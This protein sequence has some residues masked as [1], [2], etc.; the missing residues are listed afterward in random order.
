ML[1][2]DQSSSKEKAVDWKE[3]FRKILKTNE[4]LPKE[5][6]QEFRNKMLWSP[7]DIA[8]FMVEV[9]IDDNPL[10]QII[11]FAKRF[12][13]YFNDRRSQRS[14]ISAIIDLFIVKLDYHIPKLP[15]IIKGFYDYDCLEEDVI[16]EWYDSADVSDDKVKE[17]K[18][19]LVA[20]VTWLKEEE[21]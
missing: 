5:K 14:L 13:G 9:C 4:P 7:D 18:L 15:N 8:K 17:A 3:E 2:G 19:T 12:K 6:I 20:L 21:E 11:P 10:K 16:I 1:L